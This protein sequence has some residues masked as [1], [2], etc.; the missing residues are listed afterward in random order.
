MIPIFFGSRLYGKADQVPGLFHMATE[1][2]YIQ[3]LPLGPTRSFLVLEGP[4]ERVIRMG[5]SAKSIFFAYLRTALALC[6]IIGFVV[7]FVGLKEN[8]A[9]PLGPFIVGGACIPMFFL[10]YV[11]SRPSPLR[12]FRLALKAGLP[13]EMLAEHYAKTLTPEQLENLARR[14]GSGEEASSPHDSTL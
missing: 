3:F 1:F 10:T 5:L 7:G 9:A 4:G 14:V 12:A 13:M 8:K 2:F 6:C 11:V